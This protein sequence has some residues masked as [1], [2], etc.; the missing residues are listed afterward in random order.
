[1]M[2][3]QAIERSVRMASTAAET[4]VA[5]DSRLTNVA[6]S[7]RFTDAPAA[8]CPCNCKARYELPSMRNLGPPQLRYMRRWD[9][10]PGAKAHGLKEVCRT[11]ACCENAVKPMLGLEFPS[12]RCS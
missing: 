1:M 5:L 12:F 4:G 8:P 9:S 6:P 10:A 11:V 3:Q 2:L 7:G